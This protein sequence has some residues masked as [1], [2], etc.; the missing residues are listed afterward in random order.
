MPRPRFERGTFRLGGGRSIQLSYRGLVKRFGQDDNRN[1]S[2]EALPIV[3]ERC[4]SRVRDYEQR[5]CA[6]YDLLAEQYL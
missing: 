2:R 5:F 3:P 4:E 1:L 6:N